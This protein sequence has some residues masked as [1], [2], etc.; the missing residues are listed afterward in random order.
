M[1]LK[2]RLESRDS[3]YE[4]LVSWWTDWN[5]SIL[6]FKSLPQRI[7]VAYREDNES[8][9]DLY[10]IPIFMSDSD[11]CWLGFPTSNKKASKELKEGALEF[12]LDKIEVCI[13][14]QGYDRIITTSFHPKLMEAFSKRGYVMSDEKTNYYTKE[15]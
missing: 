13:K 8:F 3:Y 2:W 6:P 15:L 11:L 5:F 7:F 12:L 10:A 4:T 9:T 14:Y 1:E